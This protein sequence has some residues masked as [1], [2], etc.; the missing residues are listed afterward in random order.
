MCDPYISAFCRWLLRLRR[1]AVCIW[2]LGL[3]LVVHY[4]HPKVRRP[5]LF[6]GFGVGVG[7]SHPSGA[8][9]S[10]FRNAGLGTAYEK[11]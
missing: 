5:S 3:G 6:V 2:R 9:S 11:L 10:I 4:R 8:V 1:E 7:Q